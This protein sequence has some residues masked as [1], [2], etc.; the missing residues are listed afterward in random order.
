IGSIHRELGAYRKAHVVPWLEGKWGCASPKRSADYPDIFPIWNTEYG[1][2]AVAI[3]YDRQ[4]PEVARIYMLKGAFLYVDC[5]AV[6]DL[7]GWELEKI[8]TVQMPGIARTN[9]MYIASADMVGKETSWSQP[10]V[11][12]SIITG[13][14]YPAHFHVYAGPG[15]SKRE[16]LLTATLNRKNLDKFRDK[17]PISDRRPKDYTLLT[18]PLQ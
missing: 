2:I 16:Q 6:P 11:G 10:Y 14:R 17:Y 1:R 5:T 13:P 12:H 4:F 8:F 9:L 7:P 3:C 18:A 15:S